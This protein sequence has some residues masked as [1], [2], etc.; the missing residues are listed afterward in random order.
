[1]MHVSF[2]LVARKSA[3]VLLS[4]TLLLMLCLVPAQA[5]PA[6]DG[7]TRIAAEQTAPVQVAAAEQATAAVE[8]LGPKAWF[9][10]D[11]VSYMLVRTK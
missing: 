1:M 11:L 5:N 3:A 2:G 10:R 6:A 4:A 7:G 9:L 8:P